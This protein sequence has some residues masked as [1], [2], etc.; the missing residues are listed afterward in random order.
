[1]SGKRSISYTE[2]D[3]PIGP[4]TIFA[5]HQGVCNVQFGRGEEKQLNVKAW[6]S[7][8]NVNANIHHDPDDLEYIC[9]ELRE[10]FSNNRT[11][12]TIPIDLR[13]TAFQRLVWNELKRIE[14]GQVKTYKEIA[15]EIGSP[16]AVRA[17]GAAN[18]KNPVPI[19]VP[20]HR[21][22]GTNGS[23][24]GYA[25]GLSIKE[26]LLAHEKE[27]LQSYTAH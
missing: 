11:T 3:T 24:V 14:H 17:V 7:R 20:C 8:L 26:Q 9:T 18:N 5:T 10:Y 15:S 25:G 12:F 6:L 1:M 19:L 2:M 23:L 21:V 4:L 22:I 27:M 16:K 13:G